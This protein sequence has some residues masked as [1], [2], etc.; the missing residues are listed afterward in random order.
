[1]AGKFDI[2]FQVSIKQG[3]ITGSGGWDIELHPS[4][5]GNLIDEGWVLTAGHCIQQ[6]ATRSSI[7]LITA[8]STSVAQGNL[9]CQ[10]KD[11]VPRNY[12]PYTVLFTH[13][14][15]DWRLRDELYRGWG[16]L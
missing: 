3:N 11:I 12:E 6:W 5:S 9:F 15:Y 13:P 7:F 1:M 8:G 2:P 4:C 10:M 16:Q 14:N